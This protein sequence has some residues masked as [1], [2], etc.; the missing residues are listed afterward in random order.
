MSV[1]EHEG[2]G[3]WVERP[4][5]HEAECCMAPRG[6]LYLPCSFVFVVEDLALSPG[7]S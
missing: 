7:P 6:V 3:G 4:I 5:Q 2:G 1:I